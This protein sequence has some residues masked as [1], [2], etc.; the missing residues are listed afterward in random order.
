MLRHRYEKAG[1][2]YATGWNNAAAAAVIHMPISDTYCV[3]RHGTI[4]ASAPH[5]TCSLSI[6]W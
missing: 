5:V 3:R 4:A 6:H 1:K 2:C